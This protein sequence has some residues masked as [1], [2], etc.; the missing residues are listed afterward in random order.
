MVRLWKRNSQQA[1]QAKLEAERQRFLAT[2]SV[3]LRRRGTLEPP[4]PD[5]ELVSASL[6]PDLS[7]IALWTTALDAQAALSSEVVEHGQRVPRGRAARPYRAVLT[8][9]GGTGAAARGPTWIDD[10]DLARPIVQPLPDGGLLMVSARCR[11]RDGQPEHNAYI[12]G[13][14]GFVERSGSV[15]DGIEDVQVSASGRIWIS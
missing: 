15:G 5:L 9:H 10:L 8:W 4:R 6:G 14:H 1:F 3:P 11:M 13:A 2:T 12:Y 7:L